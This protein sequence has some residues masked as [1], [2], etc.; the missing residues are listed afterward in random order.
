MIFYDHIIV[1]GG[2]LGASIAYHISKK[3][4][5]LFWSLRET[6][7]QVLLLV[8]L[9]VWFFRDLQSNQTSH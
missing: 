8:A 7:L 6:S 4:M 2:I 9:L 1:G 5:T 3:Q